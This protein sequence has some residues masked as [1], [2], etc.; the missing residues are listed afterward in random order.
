MNLKTKDFYA[1]ALFAGAVS[2][3]MHPTK[4]RVILEQKK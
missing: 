1:G 3:Y 2:I 4:Y